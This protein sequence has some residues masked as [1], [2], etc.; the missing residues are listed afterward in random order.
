VPRIFDNIDRSDMPKL[1]IALVL[2]VVVVVAALALADASMSQFLTA[3]IS[4]AALCVSVVAA[5]KED[6]FAFRPKVVL[7]EIVLAPPS[8]PPYENMALLIPLSFV[9]TGHG[10]GIIEGLTLKVEGQGAAVKAYTPVAEV[11]YVRFMSGKRMLHADNMLGA[12]N[13]FRVRSREA[14]R[15][16]VLFTQ[17]FT[18]KR[19]PYSPWSPGKH[20]FTLYIRHSGRRLPERTALV[21]YEISKDVLADY[22]SGKGGTS[23][24][25]DR[26]LPV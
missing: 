4:L 9:N 1:F 23:L 12:F 10:A 17:E 19:Y 7:D 16:S 5:F 3:L 25:P 22:M 11:D 20:V 18:S 26:E 21:E 8:N 2:T 15:K 6:V 14:I 13:K 24:A